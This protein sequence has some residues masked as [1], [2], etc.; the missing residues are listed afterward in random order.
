[1][2]PTSFSMPRDVTLQP[3]N[4]ERR[5][6][7]YDHTEMRDRLNRAFRRR[8]SDDLES[9]V[10]KAC[11][12]GHIGTAEELL[13]VLHNLIEWEKQHFPHGRRPVDTILPQL[14]AEIAAAKAAHRAA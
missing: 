11:Q 7:T 2:K 4:T 8:L 13:T 10:H 3:L 6:E 5:L 1:M 9:L 12:R 14:A